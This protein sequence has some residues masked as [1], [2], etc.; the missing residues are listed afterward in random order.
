MPIPQPPPTTTSKSPPQIYNPLPPPPTESTSFIT[1]FQFVAT[2]DNA[3][4][5]CVPSALHFRRD[6]CGGEAAITTYL[7]DL[8][9][10]GGDLV[11]KSLGTEVMD[12]VTDQ[13]ALRDCAF[14]NV[15]LPLVISSAPTSNSTPVPAATPSIRP[16]D[17]AAVVNY[18]QKVFV[19][20]FDTFIAVYVYKGR[21]WTRLSGQIY[22]EEGDFAWAAEVLGSVCGRVGEGAWMGE[23]K[24][25]GEG[26]REVDGVTAGVGKLSVE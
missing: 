21:L 12:T 10:R 24:G 1:L 23:G 3:P 2:T 20:E 5:Y 17:V 22:L 13:H 18:M 8:A 4:Y 14:A 26:E 11:A 19:E 15:R 25:A 7:R 6:V 9:R 16:Q